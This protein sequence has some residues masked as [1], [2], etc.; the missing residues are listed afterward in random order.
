MVYLNKGACHII[1]TEEEKEIRDESTE[2]Q[3]IIKARGRI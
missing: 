3:T 1:E 2:A